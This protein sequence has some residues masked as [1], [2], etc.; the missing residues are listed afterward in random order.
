MKLIPLLQED[1]T[2][3][4][5]REKLVGRIFNLHFIS[6]IDTTF[7]FILHLKIKIDRVTDW[8][9]SDKIIVFT[10]VSGTI[11]YQEGNGLTPINQTNYSFI[12]EAL[13][14][15]KELDKAINQ[16]AQNY[17]STTGPRIMYGLSEFKI[18]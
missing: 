9:E 18:V 15:S 8:G 6:T 10:S 2:Y 16:F 5:L 13:E 4:L 12:Y 17:F 14:E 3:Q 7:G 1:A 11:D